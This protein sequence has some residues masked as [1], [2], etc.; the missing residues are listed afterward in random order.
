MKS[1]FYVGFTATLTTLVIA[2]STIHRS[3]HPSKQKRKFLTCQKTYGG[4][5]ITCGSADSLYCYNP[6]LGEVSDLLLSPGDHMIDL[7]RVAVHL[8]MGTADQA[9][10]AHPW[11]V[12]AA[13]T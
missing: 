6:T 2:E 13:T 5:S 10:F 4:G 7:N 9:T 11:Q 3:I 12:I 8:M 1:F